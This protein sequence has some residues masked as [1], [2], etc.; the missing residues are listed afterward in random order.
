MRNIKRIFALIIT[1]FVISAFS[2]S[3][4][5][6][7]LEHKRGAYDHD[8]GFFTPFTPLEATPHPVTRYYEVELSQV[9]LAPDGFVKKIF[10]INGQYPGTILHANKGDNIHV[11]VKNNLGFPSVIH[12][13]G[14]LQKGT[15]WN[16]GVTGQTQCSIP[17][18]VSFVYNFSTG[19][20]CGTYWYH[21]HTHGQYMEGLR[22]PLVIH[23]PDDP[24]RSYYD[25]EYVIT[26]SDWYHG[27]ISDLLKLRMAPNYGG[28]NPIPDSG[29][30]SGVGRYNC[31]AAP[32]N[33]QC[34]PN[35]PLAVYKVTSGK[36]YRLRLINMSGLVHYI[37]SVDNHPLKIIEA[38]GQY[39][40]PVTVNK[41]P[42]AI[43][44]RY[45]VIIEANQPVENYWMRATI[46]DRC[47]LKNQST[48]NIDSAINYKVTGI[49]RYDGA[50]IADPKSKEY[51]DQTEPCL[52]LDQSLLKPYV[53]LQVPGPA[54]NE[55]KLTATFG[56]DSQNIGRAFINNSTYAVDD[57][58]PTLEKFVNN[59]VALNQFPANQNIYSYDKW[60][61]TVDIIFINNNFAIHP[62]HMHGHSFFVLGT[63]SGIEVD[64]SKLNLIDPFP[65]DTFVLNSTSWA[66]FRYKATNPGVWTIHCHIEWHVEMGMVAQIIELPTALSKAEIPESVTDLCRQQQKSKRSRFSRRNRLYNIDMERIKV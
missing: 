37:F 28:F 43:G 29:L 58:H 36:R 63:G 14:M 61:E 12:W 45:S 6:E 26:M 10:S 2:R 13:H 8:N 9:D 64:K 32:P 11:T 1:L 42:V 34:R 35:N 50:D 46:D 33:S 3:T 44:Q 23:D 17:N 51:P 41:L 52:S 31:S 30:M 55:I 24:F 47:I 15:T 22:A 18:G 4:L 7:H 48:I 39:S 49:L 53:P 62:I 60:G 40:R 66:V 27:R 16:D 57:Q 25:L 19:E 59:K 38:D 56:V 65:R 21:S 5:Y 54:T 20:Q